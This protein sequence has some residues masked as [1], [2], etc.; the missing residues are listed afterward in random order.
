MIGYL[1]QLTAKVLL[2]RLPIPMLAV[3]NDGTI[4]FANAACQAL[5]G[6]GDSAVAGQ[7][8]NRFLAVGSRVGAAECARVLRAA[9]GAVTTWRHPR[10]GTVHTVVSQSLLL[11]A[12]DPVLLIGLIDVTEWLWTLG[13]DSTPLPLLES[14]WRR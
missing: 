5:L 11:R 2:D 13:A 14:R 4:L 1:E 7:P 6:H 3:C 9:G 12:D 10:L 8:L